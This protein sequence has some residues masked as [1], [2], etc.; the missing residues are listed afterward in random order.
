M[1]KVQDHSI[2]GTKYR[3]TLNRFDDVVDPYYG[4]EYH[5]YYLVIE[6][7]EA[8]ISARYYDKQDSLSIQ[9]G[10]TA[11]DTQLIQDVRE[12]AKSMFSISKLRLLSDDPKVGYSL[13]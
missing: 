13:L 3:I 9:K 8:R 12:I 11:N 1:D 10:L 6:S 2:N 4:A 7:K 5:G